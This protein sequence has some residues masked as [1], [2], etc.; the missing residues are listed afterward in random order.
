MP[1]FPDDEAAIIR[2]SVWPR[3]LLFYLLLGCAAYFSLV[4]SPGVVFVTLWDKAL[5]FICWAVVGGALGL[6]LYPRPFKFRPILRLALIATGIE[7]AQ[8]WVPGRQFDV[9][10]IAA[11]TLGL[12]FAASS[13]WLLQRLKRQQ[14]ERN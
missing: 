14:Q 9:N 7:A 11:N 8:A 6:A 1:F 12:L 2:H 5:H 13:W 3:W 10:D 4:P